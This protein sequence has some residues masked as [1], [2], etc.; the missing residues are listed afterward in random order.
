MWIRFEKA[1][2]EWGP[3]DVAEM[4]DW[5]ARSHVNSGF[6]VPYTIEERIQD[7]RQL[8]EKRKLTEKAAHKKRVEEASKLLRTKAK[9][10]SA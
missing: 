4:E 10:K 7:E 1:F 8:E 2:D 9:R 5:E 6:A 3:G